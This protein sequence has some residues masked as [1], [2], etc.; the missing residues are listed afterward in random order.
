MDLKV[1]DNRVKAEVAVADKTWMIFSINSS[2]AVEEEVEAVE[3]GDNNSIS[4]KDSVDI[5]SKGSHNT[6]TFLKIQMF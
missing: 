2:E 4:I 1:S 6:K 3:V 5:N